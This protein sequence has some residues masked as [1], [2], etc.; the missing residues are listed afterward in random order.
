[1]DELMPEPIKFLTGRERQLENVLIRTEFQRQFSTGG[2]AKTT[3]LSLSPGNLTPTAVLEATKQWVQQAR[4]LT[5]RLKTRELKG[6]QIDQA[7]ARLP[8]REFNKKLKSYQSLTYRCY[9][10]LQ[11]FSQQTEQLGRQWQ[12]VNKTS[13]AAN[14]QVNH[15]P[16]QV[17]KWVQ[18]GWRL[19]QDSLPN[20]RSYPPLTYATKQLVTPEVLV[21]TIQDLAARYQ[22]V[23]NQAYTEYM[24]SRRYEMDR[25]SI[26][27]DPLS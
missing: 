26:L 18:A 12:Q 19:I 2:R 1:M 3:S 14:G 13:L 22:S 25:T 23:A 9:L 15:L 6:K 24:L 21:A 27:V 16:S 11:E 17:A 7:A 4:Q 8:Y 10:A 5:T 20:D